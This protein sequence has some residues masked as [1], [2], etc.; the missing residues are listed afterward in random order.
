MHRQ[1]VDKGVALTDWC[2]DANAAAAVEEKLSM[3]E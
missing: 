3:N 1:Q 2:R